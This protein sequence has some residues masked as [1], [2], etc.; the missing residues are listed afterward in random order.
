MSQH[1]TVFFISDGT[2]ITAETLGH[3]LITQFETIAF[4]SVTIPYVNTVAKAKKVVEQIK[5]QKQNGQPLIFTTIL[6]QEIREILHTAPGRLFDLF[7]TFLQPLEEELGIQSTHTVGRTHGRVNTE[8]Y[9]IRIDAMNYALI[10]D[11]GL[12]T[13]NYDKADLILIGVS[14]TGKTPTSLYLALQFGV[15]TANYP[16]IADDM[17]HLKL[18]DCLKPYKHKIF[19]LTIDPQRL[20]EI[21][22]ERRP[23]SHYASKAQCRLEL[24]EV[25]NLFRQEK[26]PFINTTSRSIEEIST[27]ILAIAKIERRVF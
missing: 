14:R 10:N 3:S 6:S 11:D 23:D 16:F 25:E 17:D 18:P 21:R 9:K 13:H 15:L 8:S 24:S 26:I 2:G 7:A 12:G 4:D 27:K 20:C 22:S 19:G 1:R 5:A